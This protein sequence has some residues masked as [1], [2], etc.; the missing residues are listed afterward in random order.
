MHPRLSYDRPKVPIKGGSS[1]GMQSAFPISIHLAFTVFGAFQTVRDPY[2]K[3]TI[4]IFT[5]E[6]HP[7][8]ILTSGQ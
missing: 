4:S 7:G 8:T 2:S 6:K 1:K 5:W 3:Q